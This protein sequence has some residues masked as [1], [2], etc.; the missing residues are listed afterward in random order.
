MPLEG[1]R[2]LGGGGAAFWMITL[3]LKHR[4]L[5]A[6]GAIERADEDRNQ[7]FTLLKE[8]LAITHDLAEVYQF[9]F[10]EFKVSYSL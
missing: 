3:P 4:E 9:T 1:G 7:L 2:G 6:P 10:P 5:S 8:R